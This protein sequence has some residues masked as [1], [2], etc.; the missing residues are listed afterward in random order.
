MSKIFFFFIFIF[1][2]LYQLKSKKYIN[3]HG[4]LKSKQHNLFFSNYLTVN[5]NSIISKH[6]YNHNEFIFH[7]MI[8][9]DTSILSILNSSYVWHFKTD[10]DV[11]IPLSKNYSQFP[12]DICCVK[13]IFNNKLV[14]FIIA[15]PWFCDKIPIFIVDHLYVHPQFRN[16]NIADQL[17]TKISIPLLNHNGFG[18]F[19]TTYEFSHVRKEN[20]ISTIY[21][22]KSPFIKSHYNYECNFKIINSED[23]LYDIYEKIPYMTNHPLFSHKNKKLNIDYFKYFFYKN[24]FVFFNSITQTTIAFFKIKDK[25]NQFV[26]QFAFRWSIDNSS[27]ESSQIYFELKSILTCYAFFNDINNIVFPLFDNDSSNINYITEKISHSLKE[28]DISRIYFYP[29]I[30]KKIHFDRN[31]CLGWFLPR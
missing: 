14:G 22:Y 3:K 12:I 29:K 16:R 30:N 10:S 13:V 31:H 7:S 11:M 24:G 18:I 23:N 28:W 5:N 6:F 8:F 9:V 2:I 19:S 26:A 15:T 25:S 27:C 20:N 1:I 17:I 21:W 4:Y